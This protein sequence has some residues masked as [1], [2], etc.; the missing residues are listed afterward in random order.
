MD[1]QHAFHINETAM[2]DGSGSVWEI[3]TDDGERIASCTSE[4]AAEELEMAL[5]MAL[6]DWCEV[7]EEDRISN[8]RTF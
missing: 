7:D 2:T 6:T 4:E 5:N 1:I 8:A 3:V